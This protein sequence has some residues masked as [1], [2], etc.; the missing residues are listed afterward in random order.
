MHV[1]KHMHLKSV[2]SSAVSAGIQAALAVL[3]GAA[4][5]AS[6]AAEDAGRPALTHS[7]RHLTARVVWSEPE[8]AAGWV[9]EILHIQPHFL[10]LN[11]EQNI[12]SV[13]RR[14]F[15]YGPK[16]IN[17]KTAVNKEVIQ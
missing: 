3:C 8:R 1:F 2:C 6:W 11:L 12:S 17:I 7:K 15:V 9:S 4:A 5:S 14:M 10:K 16:L 13:V